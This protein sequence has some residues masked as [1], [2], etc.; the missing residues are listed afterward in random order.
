MERFHDFLDDTPA[1]IRLIFRNPRVIAANLNPV[2]THNAYLDQIMQTDS[3]IYGEQFM[4]PVRA[5][6]ADA[7]AE[8]NFCEGSGSYNHGRMIVRSQAKFFDQ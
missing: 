5:R 7:Q 8:V 4:K 1:S 6:R 2:P 3:L